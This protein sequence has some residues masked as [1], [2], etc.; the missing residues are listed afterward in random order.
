MGHLDR[1]VLLA[2][3]VRL[4]C[5]DHFERIRFAFGLKRIGLIPIVLLESGLEFLGFLDLLEAFNLVELPVEGDLVVVLDQ[6]CELQFLEKLHL[7]LDCQH[8]LVLAQLVVP[9]VDILLIVVAGQLIAEGVELRDGGS[10]VVEEGQ[11]ELSERVVRF[12]DAFV[13][14][15]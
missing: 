14:L 2:H 12:Q 13:D 7:L 8:D 5:P 3:R 15:A 6:G 1:W 9:G 10:D 11:V 4:G